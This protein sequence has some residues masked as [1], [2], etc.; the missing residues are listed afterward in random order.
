MDMNEMRQDTLRNNLKIQDAIKTLIVEIGENPERE[1]LIR[2]PYRFAKACEEWFSGYKFGADNVLNRTFA[3]KSD[4]IVEGGIRFYSFCEHHIS[5]F[6]GK[7]WIAYIPNQY[8]TGLDKMVKLVE[9]YARRLQVQERLGEQ[10]A[11]GMMKELK[12]KGVMVVIRAEHFCISS[13]ETRNPA[14]TTTSV[15]RGC[16]TDLPVRMEALE[17]M[18]NKE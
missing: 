8:V 4:M 11:D 1:G 15:I 2:T 6:F 5:P 9:I 12:P 17:L 7:V 13:R 16:F 10:I 18:R 14:I 3:E